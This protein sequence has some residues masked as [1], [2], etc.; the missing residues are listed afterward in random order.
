MLLITVGADEGPD[1]SAGEIVV[2]DAEADEDML[3]TDATPTPLRWT[4]PTC[5]DGV[6]LG[7]GGRLIVL[8]SVVQR[9]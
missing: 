9:V 6:D 8:C 4:S 1:E 2:E 3:S 7:T 5:R